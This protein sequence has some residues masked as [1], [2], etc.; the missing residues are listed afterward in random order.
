MEKENK[1]N[2]SYLDLSRQKIQNLDSLVNLTAL[3]ELNLN[4]CLNL[5]L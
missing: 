5:N 2:L 1:E 4:G 3:T